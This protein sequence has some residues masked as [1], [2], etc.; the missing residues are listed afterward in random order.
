[1]YVVEGAQQHEKYPITLARVVSGLIS[2]QQQRSYSNDETWYVFS[3][4]WSINVDDL[5]KNK[6]MVR[7]SFQVLP[8]Q[9]LSLIRLC[10]SR[11]RGITIVNEAVGKPPP[12]L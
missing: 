9:L 2:L 1:M 3:P 10:V 6:C 11:V 5:D 12:L 8:L 4:G 7:V